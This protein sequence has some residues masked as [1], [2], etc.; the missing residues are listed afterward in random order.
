[1]ADASTKTVLLGV[2]GGVAIYKAC[3]IVRAL[4]KDGLRVKVV[5]TEH[6]THFID[7]TLFRTLTREPVGLGLFDNPSDPIHHISLAK[8]ADVFAIAPCTA[9]VIAK[10]AHGIA[11]DL[12]TTTALA[13]TSPLVI[14]PAM[15]VNMYINPATQDN[16]AVLAKRGATIVE[17]DEGYLAC[18]DEGKGKLAPVD[19]IV[20]AIEQALARAGEGLADDEGLPSR[21]FGRDLEGKKVVITAGP[22]REYIDPVRY[23]SNPSTG[24]M[25][26][27]F[28]EAA[29]DRGAEVTLV[30]GPVSLLDPKGVNVVH[31]QTAQQ[32]YDAVAAAFPACDIGVFTAAVCDMRPAKEFDRKLKK[33]VDDASLA[34]LELVE[35]PDILKS[36]GQSKEGQFVIGFAAETNEVR[37]HAE[38]KLFAKAAD[39]IVANEVGVQKGFGTDDDEATLVYADDQGNTVFRELDRMDKRALADVVLTQALSMMAD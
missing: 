13:V 26:F 1:M 27:A 37:E 19:V 15:N 25:G 4:Q 29:R 2:T 32:M 7:P 20:A 10:L 16:L 17:A 9:N 18:G 35:N 3:E 36:M 24:K 30:T 11:D 38:T 31:V 21:A 28:A 12:L 34:N 23:I 39:M 8:E 14:A 6:A 22:T 5:M 33:G